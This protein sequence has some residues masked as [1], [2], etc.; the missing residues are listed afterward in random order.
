MANMV[1]QWQHCMVQPNNKNSFAGYL[2]VTRPNAFTL[3]SALRPGRMTCV[4]AFRGSPAL[5]LL[6]GSV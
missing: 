5:W 2:L 6:V 1:A 4:G 3:H